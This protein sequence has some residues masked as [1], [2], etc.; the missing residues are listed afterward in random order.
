MKP[1]TVTV[2]HYVDRVKDS[3]TGKYRVALSS[4]ENS[5]EIEL[6]VKGSYY[7]TPGCYHGAPESCFEDESSTEILDIKGPEGW[8]DDLTE[9]E[10]DLL[11]EKIV[12]S[13]SEQTDPDPPEYDDD[14]DDDR[15]NYDDQDGY[16]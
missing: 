12:E 2:S 1:T 10:E 14:Y 5:D 4:D 16:E 11:L 15:Y 9:K 3:S 7:F 8:S 13:A 6:T